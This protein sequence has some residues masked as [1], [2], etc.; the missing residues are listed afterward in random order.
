MISVCYMYIFMKHACIN[1]NRSQ[2]LWYFLYTELYFAHMYIQCKYNNYMI[3]WYTLDG[4]FVK[5]IGTTTVYYNLSKDI[6]LAKLFLQ[7]KHRVKEFMRGYY[8]MKN[9]GNSSMYVHVTIDTIYLKQYWL[10][11]I[12]KPAD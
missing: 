9:T 4:Q 5:Y 11:I 3:Y 8:I 6:D 10:Y 12:F 2:S 7:L 1:N